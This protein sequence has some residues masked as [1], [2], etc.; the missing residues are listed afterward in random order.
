MSRTFVLFLAFSIQSF[1][2]NKTDDHECD[3]EVNTI[4]QLKNEM[5]RELNQLSRKVEDQYE[6]ILS[7]K[8]EMAEMLSNGANRDL[9]YKVAC[10]FTNQWTKEGQTIS[11]D[12]ILS[13]FDNSGR[14]FGGD[15]ILN[16]TTGVYTCLMPGHYTISYSGTAV[17]GDGQKVSLHLFLNGAVVPESMWYS[18]ASGVFGQY[19]EDQGSKT[20]ILHMDHGD[21]L[22]LRTDYGFFTGEIYTLTFC[23]SLTTWDY[24]KITTVSELN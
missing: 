15:G 3:M 24:P 5:Q 11:Y 4:K 12:Y 22:E 16:T 13:D 10:A 20:L 18:F 14:P 19:L 6:E 17:I 7:L 23:V 8:E 21:L 2:G 9:P 1:L